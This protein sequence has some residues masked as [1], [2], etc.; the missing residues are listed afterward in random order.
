MMRSKTFIFVLILL[1]G[2]AAPDRKS[3]PAT[4]P[5]SADITDP[6]ATQLHDLM[7]GILL[8]YAQTK[9]LPSDLKSLK[10]P[11]G[12]QSEALSCPVSHQ[13]YIYDVVGLPGPKEGSR[14]VLYDPLPAHGGRR[15]AVMV[16]D[17]P[18][19]APLITQV[20]LLPETAF[21]VRQSR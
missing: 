1:G 4:Q 17:T 13:P 7:G 3:V 19:G 14:L 5:I 16:E 8:H 15:W 18:A 12:Q 21:S 11:T 9:A 6:C 10:L 2:C 20:L